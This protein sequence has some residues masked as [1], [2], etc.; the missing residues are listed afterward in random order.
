MQKVVEEQGETENNR[1]RW[2]GHTTQGP[3]GPR[4]E[5]LSM[6]LRPRHTRPS[7]RAQWLRWTFKTL[8]K[9]S[10]SEPKSNFTRLTKGRAVPQ[11]LG[12][13]G[14]FGIC[15]GTTRSESIG[16]PDKANLPEEL[17]H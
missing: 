12:L 15:R 9:Q 14:R 7:V 3:N 11:P 6:I 17:R 5:L 13:A 16:A 10:L 4:R 8:G 1:R 2:R